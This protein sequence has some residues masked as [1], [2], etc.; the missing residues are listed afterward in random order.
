MEPIIAKFD[1]ESWGHLAWIKFVLIIIVCNGGNSN[2][3]KVSAKEES[4][5]DRLI[6]LVTDQ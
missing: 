2:V 5:Q 4:V 3:L 6:R 1:E